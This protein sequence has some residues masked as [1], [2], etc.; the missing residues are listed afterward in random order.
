VGSEAV[1]SA[2]F[3]I[4]GAH[5]DSPNLRLK[6]KP[7]HSCEGYSQ[8]AVEVYGGVLLST[9]L[10]R[11]LGLSGRVV[12]QVGD[13]MEE[14]LLLIDRPVARIPNLAIHLNRSVNK[15]G[16][17]LNR[18]SHMVPLVGLEGSEHS[19]KSV[20]ANEL[21]CAEDQI[22]SWDLGL[23]DVQA[24]SLGGLSEDF[25]FSPRLDNQASCH[26]ATEALCSLDE[27]HRSTAVMVLF[28]HEECG[29]TSGRGAASSLLANVLRQLERNAH[30]AAHTQWE[31]AVANS[32]MV[33]VDMAHGVHP[34]YAE[35][36]DS[37]H[38]P[39]INGGPV[40]KSN[41]NMRYATDAVSS[42][43]FK[44]ICMD[45]GIPFQ[46]FINRNDLACGTTI[47]PISAA[48]LAI[49]TIDVGS[50]MLSMHSIREQGG[51][52]DVAWMIDALSGVFS[53]T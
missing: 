45:R 38:K 11:D 27:A 53:S 14:R 51:A 5:T 8:W 29:S 1:G 48:E 20:I 40:I 10:D 36:H 44:K 33:S 15:D 31:Q 9:W 34:N 6:P 32:Y 28:D 16:L 22:M 13:D 30:D 21:G 17:M 43:R 25:I 50:A 42:A 46:E 52:E 12:V 19:L 2:G 41:V 47:G 49:P 3:R 37:L 35:R 7:D 4:V 26:A 39:V 18:Q 23:H 24:P